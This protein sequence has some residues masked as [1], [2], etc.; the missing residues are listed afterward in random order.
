MWVLWGDTILFWGREKYV[1]TLRQGKDKSEFSSWMISGESDVRV[2]WYN[3]CIAN[4]D[5]CKKN[6]NMLIRSPSLNGKISKLSLYLSYT[7]L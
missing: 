1:V 7:Y 3:A 6:C 4:S 5:T 2:L